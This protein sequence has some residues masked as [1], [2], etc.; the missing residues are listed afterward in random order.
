MTRPQNPNAAEKEAR[1]QEAIT[2]VLNGEHTCHS[3][4]IVYNVP[5]RTLYDRVRGN[6]KPRNQAHECD[7]N[8]TH[9]E[10]KEL[11]RWITL[12][13]I[14]GY[15]PRYE[16]L[17]RLVEILRERRVKKT[18]DDESEV[19]VIVYDQIGK[20]WVGRFLK[21]HPELASVRP[22]SIDAVRIKDTSP[23]RLQWWFDDLE[24]V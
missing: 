19:P 11:V 13:T 10:E 22:R 20:D 1:L 5:H 7:Q 9:A 3:A 16:T 6:Q 14:S 12:L 23:E 24:K 17:R 15:P 4:A 21:R 18:A 8:L 2:A